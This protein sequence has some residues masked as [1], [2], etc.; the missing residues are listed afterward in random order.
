MH[1]L[2]VEAGVAE[3]PGRHGAV[4]PDDLP[5]LRADG[6][7]SIK[8]FLSNPRFDLHSEGYLETI[9]AAGENG[10]ISM[11][12]CEDAARFGEAPGAGVLKKPQSSLGLGRGLPAIHLEDSD[13]AQAY[14]DVVARFLGEERPMRFVEAEKR[15]FFKRLL[16]VA[17]AR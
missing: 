10:L 14:R 6:R 17:G 1:A 4:R 7:S 3:A 8:I 16:A 9:R 13:V 11:L 5:Q 2:G 15:G 12:H